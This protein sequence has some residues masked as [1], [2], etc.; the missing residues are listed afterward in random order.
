MAFELHFGREPN[1][2]LSNMLK[3]NEI[4]E[5]TKNFSL[6]AKPETLQVYTF[7]GEGG[8]SDHLPIEQRK[9]SKKN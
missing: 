9:K 2:E 3:L 8:R 4:K 6:S 1:T 7:S 5:L